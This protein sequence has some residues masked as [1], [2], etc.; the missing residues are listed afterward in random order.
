MLSDCT[1]SSRSP[2]QTLS[3]VHCD[4]A[5]GSFVR[6]TGLGEAIANACQRVWTVVRS[7]NAPRHANILLLGNRSEAGGDH[8]LERISEI[9][10]GSPL[11]LH[12]AVRKRAS[13]SESQSSMTVA[14]A[15][16]S[17][18]AAPAYELPW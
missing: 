9:A 2:L 18:D 13:P 10:L 17:K 1:L 6:T 11:V 16:S 12:C 7:E 15:G 14:T 3:S 8:H 4:A 5:L